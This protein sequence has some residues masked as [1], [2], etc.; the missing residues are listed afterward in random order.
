MS[1]IG[2]FLRPTRDQLWIA[3][4][5]L[6]P[7]LAS[8]LAPMSTVDLAYSVRAGQ[9]MLADGAVLRTDPFTFTVGGSPWLDQQWGAQVLLGVLYDAIGWAGLAV[10][11]SILVSAIVGLVFL[12]G[13]SRG[14]SV[15]VA[16]GLAL[17]GFLVA[18]PGMALRPQ[19]LGMLCFAVVGVLAAGR[20]SRPGVLWLVPIVALLWANLHGSFVLAPATVAV[21]LLDDVVARR[22]AARQALV[23]LVLTL[24]ATVVTPFGAEV[25]SYAL[26][27]SIDPQIRQ[28]VTEW[29]PTAL[30]TV[31][32]LAFFGS[33]V[34]AAVLV[35]RR[36]HAIAW[37]WLLWLV[38]LA[39]LGVIAERG[40]VWWAIGAPPLVATVFMAWLARGSAE[41]TPGTPPVSAPVGASTA[42]PAPAAAPVSTR[43]RGRSLANGAL[44]LAL[45][46]AI[47]LLLPMWRGG[48]ALY[49]PPGLLVDA[50]RGIT[51]ALLERTSPG[52][53]LFAAQRWGSWFEFAVPQAPVFADSRVE[54]IPP[55]V[56]MDYSAI[57][58]TEPGWQ[59]TLDR[60]GVT[61]LA[62]SR[63]EQ[64][65]LLDALAASA[66]WRVAFSDGVGAVYVRAEGA[67]PGG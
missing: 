49:G 47:L 40:I 41:P 33:V 48:D 3:I 39:A 2:A 57:S 51:D 7:A 29:Q 59:A 56:W 61:V 30:L 66:D 46:A 60:W 15:R 25:W 26:A 9:L 67:T 14:A 18:I 50:P 62:V 22:P 17:V 45:I 5:L 64:R 16:A 4:V 42:H 34:A 21:V 36:P 35:A 12:A 23:I 53:R 38:G 63:D 32:G 31:T 43:G 28:L 55:D 65:E 44:V 58:A 27:L 13:R 37:P 10:V 52:D 24:A 6:L 1:S 20:H 19:L 54:V 8:L 11:R